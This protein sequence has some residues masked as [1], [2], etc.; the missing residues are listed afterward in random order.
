MAVEGTEV[1]IPAAVVVAVED[2]VEAILEV[3]VAGN[4][5]ATATLTEAKLAVK[6]TSQVRTR[7]KATK[8]EKRSQAVTVTRVADTAAERKSESFFFG[9]NWFYRAKDSVI[10][11]YF[12]STWQYG[13]YIIGHQSRV[14]VNSVR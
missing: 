14:F 4:P 5:A 8:A 9:M 12:S 11:D 1:A 13:E 10:F 6:T 3:A 2:I 7:V